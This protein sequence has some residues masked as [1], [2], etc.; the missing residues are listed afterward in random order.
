MLLSKFD[1]LFLLTTLHYK[2]DALEGRLADAQWLGGQLPSGED[3]EA[4]AGIADAPN[5]DTHPNT[6][7]WWSLVSR[8]TADVRSQWKDAAGG[9]AKGG[10]KDKG[11]KKEDKKAEPKAAAADAGGDDVEFDPFAEGGDDED[12][13]EF[14]KDNNISS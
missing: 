10:K 5:P 8:F 3:R 14:G 9:A 7:A 12:V 11:G 2:M 13:S 1:R 4:H 6:F